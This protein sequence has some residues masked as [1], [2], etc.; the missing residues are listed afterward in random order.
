MK[1][2]APSGARG[3][4][5][6]RFRH[7]GCKQGVNQIAYLKIRKFPVAQRFIFGGAAARSKTATADCENAAPNFGECNRTFSKEQP[8]IFGG[9]AANFKTA[10]ANF[11]NAAANFPRCSRK[12][13]R[14]RRKFIF[15]RR[16]C[17]RRCSRKTAHTAGRPQL[18]WTPKGT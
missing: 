6:A 16:R 14:R 2:I 18:R 17:S 5:L 10:A 15:F 7:K 4:R 12:F 9:A 8:Q 3:K 13:F 1:C 11:Q